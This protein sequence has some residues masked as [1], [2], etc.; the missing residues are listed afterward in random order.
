MVL[1]ASGRLLSLH[2]YSGVC[3]LSLNMYTWNY[4]E[5]Y[6]HIMCNQQAMAVLYTQP[7]ERSTMQIQSLLAAGDPVWVRMFQRDHDSAICGEHGNLYIT[8]SGHLVKP[9]SE[10]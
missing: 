2:L 7:S 5:T 3:L 4:K 1:S 6:L 10:L 9:A 8:F